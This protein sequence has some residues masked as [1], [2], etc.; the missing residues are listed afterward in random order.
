MP[1]AR[2]SF[3]HGAQAQRRSHRG[4]PRRICEFALRDGRD[5]RLR[6]TRWRVRTVRVWGRPDLQARTAGLVWFGSVRS[7]LLFCLHAQVVL[8]SFNQLYKIDPQVHVP[9]VRQHTRRR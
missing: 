2:G 8:A 6:R 7:A 1:S 5:T 3:S 9:P 4:C